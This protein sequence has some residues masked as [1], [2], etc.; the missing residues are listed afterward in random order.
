MHIPANSFKHAIARHEL[1]FGL[2][3]LLANPIAAEVIAGSGFDWIILDTE[4]GPSDVPQ[5]LQQL[6]AMQSGTANVAARP[7]WNDKVL[8]KRLLDL[9]VQT[10]LVP[11][12]DTAEEARAAVAATRYPQDGCR[13]I[14]P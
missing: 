2:F 10:L 5:V 12:E 8:I 6:H 7:A 13:G 9:G 4:H 14:A 11:H 3:S 1:Q